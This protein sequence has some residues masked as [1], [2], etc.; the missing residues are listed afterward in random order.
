MIRSGK[1][2]PII[3]TKVGIDGTHYQVQVPV[4]QSWPTIEIYP[5]PTELDCKELYFVE[6]ALFKLRPLLLARLVEKAKE[7]EEYHGRPVIVNGPRGE[8][9]ALVGPNYDGTVPTTSNSGLSSTSPQQQVQPSL[10]RNQRRAGKTR[11]QKG[12]A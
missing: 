6:T 8:K 9:I 1:A 11:S 7:F 2:G 5:D 4:S 3:K 10:N 12:A